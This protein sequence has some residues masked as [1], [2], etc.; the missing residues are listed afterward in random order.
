MHCTGVGTY[1][2]AIVF[3]KVRVI[4][5]S[6]SVLVVS[7]LHSK[8]CVAHLKKEVL[9]APAKE[10]SCAVVDSFMKGRAESMAL[11]FMALTPFDI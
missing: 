5:P 6:G 3:L 2:V 8:E 1:V 11:E 7:D 10:N 9:Y 4:L